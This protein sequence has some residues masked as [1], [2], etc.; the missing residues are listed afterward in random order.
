MIDSGAESNYLSPQ[1]LSCFNPKPSLEKKNNI[2]SSDGSVRPAEDSYIVKFVDVKGNII[3]TSARKNKALGIQL[4]DDDTYTSFI[5]QELN[6]PAERIEEFNLK[7]SRFFIHGIIGLKNPQ[8]MINSVKPEEIGLHQN[9]TLPNLGVFQSSLCR[10]YF[11][12]GA[13]GLD[14]QLIDGSFPTFEDPPESIDSCSFILPLGRAKL[15]SYYK[16]CFCKI[17]FYHFFR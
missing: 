15:G 10:G 6:I 5:V 7:N 11:I 13:P 9:I 14:E 1:I 3:N 8:F 12:C 17:V 2:K 16:R 4:E